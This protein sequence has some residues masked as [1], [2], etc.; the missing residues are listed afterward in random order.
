[1]LKP[2][3]GGASKHSCFMVRSTILFLRATSSRGSV[4]ESNVFGV[5]CIWSDKGHLAILRSTPVLVWRS[6]ISKKN[7]S[8]EERRLDMRA[9][10]R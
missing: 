3:H 1:M 5:V 2:H 10:G 9:L 8:L 4:P 7:R 6:S